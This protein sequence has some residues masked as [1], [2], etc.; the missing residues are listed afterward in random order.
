MDFHFEWKFR[1]SFLNKSYKA[2]RFQKCEK[3]WSPI[4]RF[5]VLIIG[6][7]TYLAPLGRMSIDISITEGCLRW[8]SPLPYNICSYNRDPFLQ[9]M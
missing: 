9:N 7:V 6:N 8:H 4:K 5:W 3:P 1:L 2:T